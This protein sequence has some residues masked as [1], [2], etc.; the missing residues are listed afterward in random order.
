MLYQLMVP[1]DHD[2]AMPPKGKEP[3]TPEQ[4]LAISRWIQQGAPFE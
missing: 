3:L 1:R 4:I 2:D